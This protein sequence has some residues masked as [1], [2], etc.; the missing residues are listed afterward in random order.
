M[1]S[2]SSTIAGKYPAR[3]HAERVV[4]YIRSK[5]PNANGTIYLEGQKTRM[6]EDSDAAQPF[7][8]THMVALDSRIPMNEEQLI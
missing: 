7:R 1:E 3:A 4:A 8:Y 2:I 6:I 5:E